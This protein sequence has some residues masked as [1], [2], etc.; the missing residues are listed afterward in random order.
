LVDELAQLAEATDARV[1]VIS[2]QTEEG[3][4]LMKSFGGV[5]AIL[6]FKQS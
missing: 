1:E 4:A 2:T 5:A 6:R 3:V